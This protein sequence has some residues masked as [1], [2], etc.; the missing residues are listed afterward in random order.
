[1]MYVSFLFL[2]IVVIHL[3]K[4]LGRYVQRY[5]LLEEIV[6]FIGHERLSALA[7]DYRLCFVAYKESDASAVEN[8]L[9]VLQIFV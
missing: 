1:M 8:Y 2:F 3:G 9:M 4:F 6:D 5:K 7:Q